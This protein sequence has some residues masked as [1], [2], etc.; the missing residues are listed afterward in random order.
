MVSFSRGIDPARMLTVAA[1]GDVIMHDRL[2]KYAAGHEDGFYS[3]MAPVADI[4]QAADVSFANLEGPAAAGVTA[5]GRK[6]KEPEGRYDGMVYAGYPSF[7]YHPSIAADLKRTG[8]D[9][10]LTAN[11]HALDRLSAGADGTVR[12][13]TE[14]GLPFTG[15]RTKT[16]KDR[17]WHVI[18][19]VD[20]A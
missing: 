12:T 10:V 1:V 7:N 17:P 9:V 16:D 15:S 5:R 14:A 11:N 6:V 2:Q 20:A 13:L 4:I 8:F 19:P 3:M 18:T